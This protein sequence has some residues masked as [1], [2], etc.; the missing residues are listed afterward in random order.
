MK[1]STWVRTAVAGV[2][3]ALI[4]GVGGAA[5]AATESDVDVNVDIAPIVAP[6]ALAL[7]VAPGDVL[8]NESGSTVDWRQFTG[9]LPTVTVTSSAHRPHSRETQ[10]S[11]RSPLHT[12][13]GPRSSFRP[14]IR[15]S[16]PR[17]TRS[18]RC[19]MMGPTQSVL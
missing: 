9:T 5:F 18:T 6:G 10:A 3:A 13:A 7:T 4:V 16:S 2:G 15:V 14:V 11:P 19:W 12:W 17:V 1:K 8:L